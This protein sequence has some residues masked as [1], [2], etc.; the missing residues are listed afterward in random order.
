MGCIGFKVRLDRNHDEFVLRLAENTSKRFCRPDDLIGNAA[1]LN[2]LSNWI[3]SFEE[4][5]TNVVADKSN[6]RVP[7]HFGIGQRSAELN[8]NIADRRHVLGN[9]FEINTR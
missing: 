7:P 5:V 3:A 6:R 9:S 8:L 1:Y 2:G 4:V